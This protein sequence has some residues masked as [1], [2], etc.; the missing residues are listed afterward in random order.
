MARPRR[1]LA[2]TLGVLLLGSCASRQGS[3]RA[4]ADLASG[5]MVRL[6][7]GQ[8]F[9]KALTGPNRDV[10]THDRVGPF[11]LDTTE[12]TVAAYGECVK[13]GKCRPAGTT[14]AWEWVKSSERAA[15]S[16]YC[17]GDRADRADHPVNCVEWWQAAG[18]C[19]WV[20]KRLP[21][22]AEWE[23]AARNG[24]E[25]TTSPWGN[26]PPAAQLCW[27]GEGNDMGRG[28]RDSTCRVGSH[29]AGAS[30]LGIQD[31]AGGVWEWTSS[32]TVVGADSRGRGGTPVKVARG[33]G[34]AETEPANVTAAVRFT[35]LPSRRDAQIGFRCA[36]DP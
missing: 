22:E 15:W 9:L 1:W 13:A 4:R 24:P 17:N 25:G 2:A 10:P 30:R 16:V 5:A 26:D 7:A 19:A 34:W 28:R 29:P 21:T 11:L 23:W 8:F 32:E 3:E 6:P 35:D 18:Y 20:G 33:G 27:N 36:S 14:V 31:L 12:V